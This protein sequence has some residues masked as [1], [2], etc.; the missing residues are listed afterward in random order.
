MSRHEQNISTS[1]GPRILC[2]RFDKLDNGQAELIDLLPVS[3]I[4]RARGRRDIQIHFRPRLNILYLGFNNTIEPFD[5]ETAREAIATGIN[6]QDLIDFYL[7]E[8]S[9]PAD[10]L[11]PRILYP[12][13]TPGLGWYEFNVLDSKR[14]LKEAGVAAGTEITLYFTELDDPS[15]PDLA[16]IA[17][18]IK[19]QLQLVGLTV[20][21][22]QMPETDFRAAL[23]K[24]ALGFF[25]DYKVGEYPDASFFYDTL[26]TS[27]NQSLGRHYPDI[28]TQ[29]YQAM[30]TTDDGIRQGYYDNVNDMVKVHVPFIPVAYMSS[31]AA[32]RSTVENVVIGPMNEN[33]VQMS[34]LRDIINFMPIH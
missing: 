29:I 20:A 17:E 19:E 30:E 3:D 31:V 18:N 21:L 4:S 15:M 6:R 5:N 28:V 33:L 24:G 14:Q 10:Q 16:L 34:T 11:I 7:P 9:E 26:F 13:H 12:G 32:N 27:S 8:G 22:N 23:E 1:L 2:R 25:I